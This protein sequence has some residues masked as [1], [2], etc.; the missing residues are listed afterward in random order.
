MN[1]S[2]VV[3]IGGGPTGIAAATLLGHE[4]V[5]VLVL[6]RWAGVFP[7]PRAVHLDAEVMRILGRI[8]I[9]EEFAAISRQ[10]K[11]LRLQRPDGQVLAVFERAAKLGRDGYPEANMFD[12]PVL[13]QLLRDNLAELPS[14]QLRGRVEVN[15]IAQ[16]GDQ[17]VVVELSDLVT[18]QKESISAAYVLG[19]DGANSVVRDNIGAHM[20]DLRFEQRWLVVDIDTDAELGQWEGVHQV[21]D[22]R[23]AA[24]YM[25]V[26]RRRHRWEFQLLEHETQDTYGSLALLYPLM[27]P[28]LGH[29]EP[30]D[31]DLVRIASYTFKARL[32]DRWR[33]RR[34][35]L[36]GDAAHL[37]PP[38][39]GQGLCAGLRDAANLSWKLAAVMRGD[40]PEIVL[41]SYQ[42]ERKPHARAMIRL[43]IV[44]G[45]AMTGGGRLGSALRG[46]ILPRLVRVPGLKAQLLDSATPRLTSS[47]LAPRSGRTGLV[48]GLIPNA[49]LADGGRFDDLGQG[50][51]TLVTTEASIATDLPVLTVVAGDPLHGWLLQGGATTA[52]VR[53][54]ATVAFAGSATDVLSGLAGL[55]SGG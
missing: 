41:D 54:D 25:Q 44:V 20:T 18:G 17:G 47:A 29:V 12:Q 5:E 10:A 49:E 28:W 52:A 55:R 24:T 40:L 9:A 4:G 32:A 31:L 14:V 13:E 22:S 6:D 1:R 48:G 46:V 35:F 38:F 21:C 53:P 37:T 26:G 50:R 16:T 3:V 42:T 19:C 45:A 11:G 34:V 15:S 8:G 43:A 33:D 30:E 39:V 23:R 7:Q 2:P 36:L 51:W 27:K